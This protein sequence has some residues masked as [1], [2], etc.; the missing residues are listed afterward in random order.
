M[1]DAAFD[2]ALAYGIAVYDGLFVALVR[3]LKIGGVTA[4]VP[5]VRAVGNDFPEIVLLK[6]W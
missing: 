1:L 2:I 5:L 3:D 6:D 4:D